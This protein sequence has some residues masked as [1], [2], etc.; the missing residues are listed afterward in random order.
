MTPKFSLI[1]GIAVAALVFAAPAAAVFPDR[2][3]RR[4]RLRRR[5]AGSA[6]AAAPDFWNYD[7]SGQKVTDASPGVA[8]EE[9]AAMFAGAA[10][11][12]QSSTQPTVVTTGSTSRDVA[13]R[14]IGV[15]VG[16]ALVLGLLLVTRHQR[17]RQL[18]H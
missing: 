3:R 5:A 2:G 14:G 9:L 11:A 7:A 12:S 17:I 6:V 4:Q 16:V 18:A 10:G 8:P 1:I 13:S 15:A